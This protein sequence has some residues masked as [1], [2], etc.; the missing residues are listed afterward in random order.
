[1]IYSIFS[2]LKIEKDDLRFF[3][4]LG[5]LS[6]VLMEITSFLPERV[7]R[8]L[9]SDVISDHLPWTTITSILIIQ[10]IIVLFFH[11]ITKPTLKKYVHDLVEHAAKKIGDFCSPA[12]SIMFGLSLACTLCA[13]STVSLKYLGYSFA[14]GAFS[15][16][17][18]AFIFMSEF[19]KKAIN[20]KAFERIHFN[21]EKLSHSLQI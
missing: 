16:M 10:A 18:I 9:F 21:H 6:G 2:K 14:F 17:F 3:F 19:L 5:A 15:L 1:M 7:N 13:L 11:T 20:S 4:P 8:G 12:F